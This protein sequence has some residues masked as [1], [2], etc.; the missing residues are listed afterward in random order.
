[1]PTNYS[2]QYQG[3]IRRQLDKTVLPLTIRYL[4][5]YQF[6]EKIQM[7]KGAGVT[8]T[9]TRFNR[10]PLPSAPLAEGVPPVGETMTISQVT[11]VALQWGDR[12]ILTDVAETTTLY[13][14]TKQAERLLSIQMREMTERNTYAVLA[15][16]TQVNYVASRGSRALLVAGDVMDLATINRT[17]ADLENIGA[18]FYNG[19]MEPTQN[20]AI[21][22]GP[23][24]S[25]KGPMQSE[26]YVAITSPFVEQDLRQNPTVVQAWSY[27]DVTRLY[28]NE[29][30]YLAGIHFTKSNMLPRWTGVAAVTGTAGTAGSLAGAPTNYV[31]QV[32]ANDVLN[33][34]GETLVYQVSGAIAV[35]GPNGSIS[36]TVPSTAGYLYNIYISLGGATSATNLGLTNSTAAPT[37]GPLAGQ[38]AL[39]PP[40]TTAVITGIGLYQ[41]PPAAPATGVTVYP[42]FVFGKEYFACLQLENA[43]WTF[44]G[45][46]DKS[47]PLNQL[48]VIGWKLFE[49]FVILNQQF[50][51]R[52]ESSVSN[53]GAFG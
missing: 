18:P 20:R 7:E 45:E 26:H 50:G 38:A 39:L 1:V 44:L 13:D 4:V 30:G 31:I 23:R 17:F 22:H 15:S 9:A 35:T 41:I 32:T 37:I 11:G 48:R 5:G 46:A 12:V 34:L 52:I 47:D 10:L 40:G 6:A 2:G 24:M 16:G 3:A 53:S 42:T 28:I 33:Q 51:A 36:V 27:S 49:G 25:E 14:L 8:W 29:I 43:K 19:Q 21:E